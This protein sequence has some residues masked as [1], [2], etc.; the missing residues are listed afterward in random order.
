MDECHGCNLH[1][2]SCCAGAMF[3]CDKCEASRNELARQCAMCDIFHGCKLCF[4]HH[5]EC[6]GCKCE[7]CNSAFCE[8]CHGNQKM[9]WL[10]RS[11]LPRLQWQ[12][13]PLSRAWPPDL[14]RL[15]CAF[16]HL[17][18]MSWVQPLQWWVWRLWVHELRCMFLQE[19]QEAQNLLVVPGQTRVQNMCRWWWCVSPKWLDLLDAPSGREQW[20]K[21]SKTKMLKTDDWVLFL[22]SPSSLAVCIG[23]GWCYCNAIKTVL[24]LHA[25]EW[26]NDAWLQCTAQTGLRALKN[27][28]RGPLRMESK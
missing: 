13:H 17:W 26:W 7:D 28:W 9:P 22:C 4:G 12:P 24:T 23:L 6:A 27:A 18:P 11:P 10:P 19:V 3:C 15:H 20:R 5:C 2:V 21:W 1:F 8:S 25:S 14:Q 16:F